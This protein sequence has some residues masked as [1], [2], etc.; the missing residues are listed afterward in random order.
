MM[1]VCPSCQVASIHTTSMTP[2]WLCG[3][4]TYQQVV[5][6]AGGGCYVSVDMCWADRLPSSVVVASVCHE[7]ASTAVGLCDEHHQELVG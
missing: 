6:V 1:R 2:C 7:K 4:D 3:G 5:S